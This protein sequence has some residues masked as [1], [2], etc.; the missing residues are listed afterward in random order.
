MVFG[1]KD[2]AKVDRQSDEAAFQQSEA[3]SRAAVAKKEAPPPKPVEAKVPRAASHE[4]NKQQALG[5]V[6]HKLG[7]LVSVTPEGLLRLEN[8]FG[9]AHVVVRP[10]RAEDH[11]L[12]P[13]LALPPAK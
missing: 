2:K 3:I 5:P 1:K 6:Q 7:P 10:V 4:W 8:Q 12:Y 9:T 11:Q 13:N